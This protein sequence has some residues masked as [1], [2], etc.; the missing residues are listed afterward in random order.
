MNDIQLVNILHTTNN[1]LEHPTCL[2]F[3]NLFH[4][5]DV[6]E[7]LTVLHVLHHEEQL[8]GCLDYLV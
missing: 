8:F 3:G 1:L 6:V 2:V 4:L 7:Q 5:D